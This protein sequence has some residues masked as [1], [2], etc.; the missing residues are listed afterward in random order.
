[1]PHMS[2]AFPPAS[3][4]LSL[5]LTSKVTC[6]ARKLTGPL[7]HLVSTWLKNWTTSLMSEHSHHS[8]MSV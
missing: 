3:M 2:R 4:Q 1:M 7:Y 8:G 5:P 6:T